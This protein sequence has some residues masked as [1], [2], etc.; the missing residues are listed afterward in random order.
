MAGNVV[1]ELIDRGE[2]QGFIKAWASALTDT[3]EFRF[4]RLP[5]AV[6]AWIATASVRELRFRLL[7]S[8]E[9]NSLAEL[10]PKLDLA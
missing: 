6:H 1:Q 8:L 3:L 10:F 9:A 4:G 7:D 2:A 5:G